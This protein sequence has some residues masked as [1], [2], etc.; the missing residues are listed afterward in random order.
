MGLRQR[1]EHQQRQWWCAERASIHEIIVDNAHGSI[2]AIV[3]G[4]Q[5]VS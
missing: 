5:I 3:S 4:S 2:R 1:M